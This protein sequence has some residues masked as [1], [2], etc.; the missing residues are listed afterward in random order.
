MHTT[1]ILTAPTGLRQLAEQAN[2]HHREC[3]ASANTAIDHAHAAGDALILAKREC[4]RG[5]F[6]GWVKENFSGSPRTAR[7]YMAVAKRWP[8]IEAKRQRVANLGLREAMQLTRNA[9]PKQ[10]GKSLA[11]VRRAGILL[12]KAVALLIP[13]SGAHDRDEDFRLVR[14]A[15]VLL[16]E[17]KLLQAEELLD[18]SLPVEYWVELQRTGQQNAN[19]AAEYTLRCERQLGELLTVA[20]RR[21]AD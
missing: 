18:K 9:G 10:L 14:K 19:V 21:E 8:Q 13:G 11:L 6:L 17:A 20:D 7:L 4:P 16:Y 1:T 15:V 2:F 12:D 5:S 3:T